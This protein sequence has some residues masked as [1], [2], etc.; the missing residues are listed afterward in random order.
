MVTDFVLSITSESPDTSIVV[1][2]SA[3]VTKRGGGLG[4]ESGHQV[5]RAAPGILPGPGG[6]DS[7]AGPHIPSPT[8]PFPADSV[9]LSSLT[10]SGILGP[11]QCSW[12]P[13]LVRQGTPSKKT[14]HELPS[15]FNFLSASGLLDGTSLPTT[16]GE[17]EAHTGPLRKLGGTAGEGMASPAFVSCLPTAVPRLSLPLRSAS[18]LA[19]CPTRG[20]VGT[21]LCHC[22]KLG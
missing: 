19:S 12:P 4:F 3:Q 6:S 2:Y 7:V 22:L 14:L 13:P 11:R 20:Q 16:L 17:E 1:S 9:R 15:T 8:P 5:G 10:F 21:D 18:P